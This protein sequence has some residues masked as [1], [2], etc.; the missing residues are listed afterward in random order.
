[1]PLESLPAG[2]SDLVR[3]F[4]IKTLRPGQVAE[5][6]LGK[7]EERS[8]GPGD[9]GW[10]AAQELLQVGGLQKALLTYIIEQCVS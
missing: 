5:K 9:F 1:M 7:G 10:H 6:S 2:Q 4:P 8:S 3:R